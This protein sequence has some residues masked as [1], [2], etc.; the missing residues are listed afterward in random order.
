MV[1]ACQ[2]AW[3]SLILGFF[4]DSFF[5]KVHCCTRLHLEVNLGRNGE[6]IVCFCATDS[7]HRY[8]RQRGEFLFS[9]II[10]VGLWVCTKDG[11]RGLKRPKVF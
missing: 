6:T 1:G 3:G 11:F 10:L 2:E 9:F 7:L 5:E 8:Q 4:A